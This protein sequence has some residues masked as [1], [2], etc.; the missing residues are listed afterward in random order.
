MNAV[1]TAAILV[2]ANGCKTLVS[3]PEKSTNQ[4]LLP[5]KSKWRRVFEKQGTTRKLDNL[6]GISFE[7]VEMHGA[8]ERERN[9]YGIFVT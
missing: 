7:I 6:A 5:K 3:F 9:R 8:R 1:R 4:R 2:S